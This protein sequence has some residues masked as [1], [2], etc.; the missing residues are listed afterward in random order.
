M[1]VRDHLLNMH[2]E[3]IVGLARDELDA[4]RLPALA[5][6]EAAIDALDRSPRRM[7]V[8][9]PP[10]EPIRLAFYSKNDSTEA[11]QVEIVCDKAGRIVAT[12]DC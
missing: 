11:T 1:T 7:V 4:G 12:V 3:L 5:R 9:A 6:I 10:G 8:I 2:A